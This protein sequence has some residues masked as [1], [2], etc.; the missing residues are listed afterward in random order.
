MVAEPLMTWNFFSTPIL[1]A[2]LGYFIKKLIDDTQ[3]NAQQRNAATNT[4]LA[5]IKTC[6]TAIKVDMESKMDR[7][8]CEKRGNE[9]WNVIYHHKHT[10]AGEVVVPQ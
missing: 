10:E 9:K 1:I 5:A 4:E 8:D 2:A 3:L 7:S 6:L